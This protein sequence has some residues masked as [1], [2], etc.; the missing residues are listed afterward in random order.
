[1]KQNRL[2]AFTDGVI[3]ILITIM[4]LELKVPH[5]DNLD[6]LVQ[7]IPKFLSYVLS[8]VYLGIYWNNHHHMLHSNDKV[9]GPML[10]ANLHLLFW[11]SLVPFATGWMGENHFESIPTM[12]YGIVLLMAAIAYWILQLT[13]I[14]AQGPNSILK[15]AV[16]KDWKGKMSPILY[17]AAILFIFLSKWI[18]IAIYILVALIWLIPDRRIERVITNK[19]K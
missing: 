14:S 15:K 7:L 9:T 18:S 8:F 1:M 13:I 19:E 4:V 3:A 17:A 5:G 12:F 6:T 10:W 16:N 11:L 2:E